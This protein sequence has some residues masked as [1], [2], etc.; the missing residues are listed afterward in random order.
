[1]SL[2]IVV[3]SFPGNTIQIPRFWR[4]EPHLKHLIMKRKGVSKGL[5]WFFSVFMCGGSTDIV[6]STH[7]YSKRKKTTHPKPDHVQHFDN[8]SYARQTKE[9]ARSDY[10]SFGDGPMDNLLGLVN[11]RVSMSTLS[12]DS[13]KDDLT[14]DPVVSWNSQPYY[15]KKPWMSID[16]M[17]AYSAETSWPYFPWQI[18]PPSPPVQRRASSMWRDMETARSSSPELQTPTPEERSSFLQESRLCKYMSLSSTSS[19]SQNT[20]SPCGG[21]WDGREVHQMPEEPG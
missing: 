10:K 21:L 12:M 1:M 8:I 13:R 11:L 5:W 14:T 2:N 7:L 6:D 20:V 4:Q 3:V 19:M 15:P 9:E 16:E 18:V 17:Q